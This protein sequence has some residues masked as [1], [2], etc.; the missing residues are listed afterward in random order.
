MDLNFKINNQKLETQDKNFIV[1]KSNNYLR[2]IFDFQT[3][4][5][6]GTT[7]FLILQNTDKENYLFEITN[8]SVTVPYDILIGN[9]FKISAYG[10]KQDNTRITTNI[11]T[12]LLHK[13][14]YTTDLNNIE[15]LTPS[16]VE[17]LY[18]K[19]NQ[20]ASIESLDGKSDIDHTHSVSDVS[21]LSSVAI[22]GDY[23]DL[24]NKPE[25]QNVEWDEVLNKPS[26]YPPS[27]HAH[28]EYVNI[29]DIQDNLTSTDTNKPLSANQG[30]VL[31]G[32]V[33][34]KS[35]TGHKHTVNDVTDLTI[36]S[37][38][39]DLVNDGDGTNVFIKDNDSRLS[40]SRTPKSHTHTKSQITDFPS[41]PSKTSDLTNDGD[42]TNAF[43]KNNDSRLTDARTPTSHEHTSTEVKDSNSANYSNIGTLSANS[44]QQVIN[45]AINTSLNNYFKKADIADNLTTDDSTKAL[46]A[47]QGKVLKDLIG[48]IEEDMLL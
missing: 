18:M 3:D 45:G 47:K 34:S 2:L 41:I 43:I 44:T 37:K 24:I 30:M 13:S 17:D 20:K 33:D 32:L 25:S 48:N 22:T 16:V 9:R 46:S 38:T 14:G 4:D 26:S 5:W 28:T 15:D 7:K 27:A 6:A 11:I 42:G 19:L 23:N 35:D 21:G 12:I 40:D 10:L 29:T 1:Q 8:N 36:P 39:S 31:K